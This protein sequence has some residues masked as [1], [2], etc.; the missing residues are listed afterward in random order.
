[1]G[2]KVRKRLEKFVK[3]QTACAPSLP[4]SHGTAQHDFEDII[5]RG[6]LVPKLCPVFDENL[7]YFFYGRSEYRASA[8]VT[9]TSSQPYLPV[10][11]LLSS[12]KRLRAKR[13]VPFDSGAFEV[14]RFKDFFKS[15]SCLENFIF[16]SPK[17]IPGQLVTAFFGTN[18]D[19]VLGGFKSGSIPKLSSDAQMLADLYSATGQQNFDARR[20]AIEIQVAKSFPLNSSTVLAV[21]L[22]RTTLDDPE[23][24]ELI[25]DKWDAK[26]LPYDVIGGSSPSEYCA[27]IRQMTID[28]LRSEEFIA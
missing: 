14:G 3:G 4:W 5:D 18:E 15:P 25:F 23:I 28:F 22:A 27:V 24:R 20:S 13:F 11:L 1:M 19:Y 26:V 2:G 21:A 17:S 10:F 12:P 16:E 9:G 7:T 8:G 6:G